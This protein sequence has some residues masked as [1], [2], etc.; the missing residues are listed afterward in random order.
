[1][2]TTR[3]EA[4]V[5]RDVL[6]AFDGDPAVRLWRNSV[7]TTEEW[8]ASSTG[9]AVARHITY[10]LGPGSPDVVGVLT[11]GGVGVMVGIEVKSATGRVRPEQAAWL[12]AGAA[13]GMVT[14]VARSADDARAIVAAGRARVEEVL[15]GGR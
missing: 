6:R 13:R 10:G 14:G 4:D 1:M 2:T 3:R 7:G 11:V 12:A 15:R 8:G 5:L 9:A